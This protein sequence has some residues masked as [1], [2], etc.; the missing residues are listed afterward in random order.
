MSSSPFS[1]STAP[2]RRV[3]VAWLV[4]AVL[5]LFSIAAPLNQFK[6]PPILPIVMQSFAVSVGSAGLVMSVFVVTGLVLA[7]PA[8]LIFQR[9]GYRLTTLLAGG[10]I[11]VGAVWGALSPDLANLL[12][13]RVIEGIGT[14]FM[15][16]M[17]PAVI[18]VWFPARQRGIAMGIWSDWV[19]LGRLIML[20]LAPALALMG[21]WRTVWW[22]GAAYAMA[23]TAIALAVVRPPR[24][25][26]APADPTALGA[27]PPAAGA[28]GRVLRN[29]NLWL[30]SLTFGLLN[31]AFTA[32]TTYLPTYLNKVRGVP[33][34]LAAQWLSL[35]TIPLLIAAPLAGILSDRLGS[36]K[37]PY[38]VGVSMSA[39]A[40]PLVA[41]FTGGALVVVLCLQGLM[42]GLVAP[43]IFS[44]AVE[45]VG[46]EH[47]GGLAMGVVMIGQNAGQLLGPAVFG[48]LVEGAGGWPLA[49]GSLPL[50][51]L[52]GVLAGSLAKTKPV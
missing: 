42:V 51:C 5:L 46:D 30:I 41:L 10:S 2:D 39:I 1:A 7:L 17:A 6:V 11:A 22:F 18:A 4:L 31:L 50:V 9:A 36:R 43:N 52:L 27:P 12:A 19:P 15:A 21:T 40:A 26:N 45:V 14:S 16:V 48:L 33:L 44:A 34:P 23:V 28:M 20:L 38:L 37:I 8:G 3:A 29:G 47:L 24:A 13:S 49:F 25:P 32:S 35:G